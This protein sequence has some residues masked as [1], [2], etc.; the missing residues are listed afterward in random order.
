MERRK[1]LAKVR[2]ACSKMKKK[3][4]VLTFKDRQSIIK[5]YDAKISPIILAE[6]YKVEK[7]TIERIIANRGII[8]S[9]DISSSRKRQV[10]RSRGNG[11]RAL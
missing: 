4:V 10:S 2:E 5:Q 9:G 8:M 6:K 11:F 7:R 3:R 1:T